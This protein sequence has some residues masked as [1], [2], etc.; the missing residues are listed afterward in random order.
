M[1]IG[2]L[3]NCFKG[4]SLIDKKQNKWRRVLAETVLEKKVFDIFKRIVPYISKNSKILDIGT[5]DGSIAGYLIKNKYKVR[6]LDVQNHSLYREIQPVIYDGWNIP[7]G[8]KEFDIA[9]VI[10]V[11][12]HCQDG[13]RVLNEAKRVAKRVIVIEDTFRNGVEKMMVGLRDCLCNFEFFGHIYRDEREWREIVRKRGWKLTRYR[14]W[15]SV[16]YGIL[17]GR[18]NLMVID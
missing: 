7:F 8:D 3:A 12:H 10:S 9:L 5:G 16:F 4:I 15:S 1:P 2:A 6:T 18:Q 14:E 17:Y 11:L 13:L